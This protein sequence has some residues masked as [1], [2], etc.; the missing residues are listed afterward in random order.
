MR[1]VDIRPIV[2]AATRIRSGIGLARRSGEQHRQTDS[3]Q[4]KSKTIHRCL[5]VDRGAIEPARGLSFAPDQIAPRP[6]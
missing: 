4:S 1:Y 2:E 5:F 6:C 3:G